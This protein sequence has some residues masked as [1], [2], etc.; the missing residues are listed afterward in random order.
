ME[1]EPCEIVLRKAHGKLKLVCHIPGGVKLAPYV[2]VR[3]AVEIV[4][5]AVL[6]LLGIAGVDNLV[7]VIFSVRVY[8]ECVPTVTPGAVEHGLVS[9]LK[10]RHDLVS[11]LP[12]GKVRAVVCIINGVEFDLDVVFDLKLNEKG[13][14]PAIALV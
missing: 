6:T 14:V 12:F 3:L 1:I 5:K 8:A 7:M 2:G 11:L 9:F 10:G 13:S 4:S